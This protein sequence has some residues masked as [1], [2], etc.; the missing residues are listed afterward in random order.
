MAYALITGASS[1]IGAASADALAQKGWNLILAARRLDRL[2][3]ASRELSKKYKVKCVPVSM[4]VTDLSSVNALTSRHSDILGQIKLL[5]N[6]AGLAVGREP[7]QYT[8]PEHWN[9]MIDTNVKGLLNVTHLV[10]P[11]LMRNQ[12]HIIHIG[13][14][15]GRWAYPS[16]AVYCASKAAVKMLN[17]AMRLDLHGTGV[18]VTTIDPGMVETEFSLVRFGDEQVAKKVYEGMTPLSPQ[19]VADAVVWAASRPA[20]VNIQEIVLYPTDQASVTMVKRG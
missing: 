16:G 7:I 17:E 13:S 12:G 10:L 6:N 18:R 3:A 2:E 5:L 4:D 8:Q 15:A 1:G 11:H 20:H 14:V 9:R 19:D